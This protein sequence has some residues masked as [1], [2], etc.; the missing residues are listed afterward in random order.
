[1]SAPAACSTCPWLAHHGPP[2]NEITP[3]PPLMNGSPAHLNVETDLSVV[4]CDE[5]Y[6]MQRRRD[7]NG[8]I[9]DRRAAAMWPV[10][11]VAAPFRAVPKLVPVRLPGRPG[12]PPL[13]RAGPTSWLASGWG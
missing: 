4:D 2:F 12:P 6:R 11:A 9:R 1:M 13:V 8:P 3:T 5:R 10:D 7:P